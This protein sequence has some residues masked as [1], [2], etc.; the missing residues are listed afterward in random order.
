MGY[1]FDVFGI[2]GLILI[3]VALFNKS[4]AWRNKAF[5]LGVLLIVAYIIYSLAFG[6]GI[7][8]FIEGY[9]KGRTDKF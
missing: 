8:D 7:N 2:V 6:E 4:K 1:I 3:V 5:L 9:R